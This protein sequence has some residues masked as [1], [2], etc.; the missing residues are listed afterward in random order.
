MLDAGRI[1]LD[2]FT[3]N[4][5]RRRNALRW[6]MFASVNLRRSGRKPPRAIKTCNQG[7]FRGDLLALNGFDERMQGWGREDD[8]LAWRAWHAGIGARH[9]RF[10]ALAWHLHHKER[11]V[12]GESGNDGYLQDTRASQRTRAEHGIDRH[13]AEFAASPLPDLRDAR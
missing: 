2:V 9:L 11:H 3:P 12:D 5:Q 1:D 8:E 10:A 4:L 13:L 6:P 7:W